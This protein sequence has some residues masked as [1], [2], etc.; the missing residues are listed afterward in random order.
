MTRGRESNTAYVAV[1]PPDVAHVGPRPGD[2][3]EASARS[4]LFGILQQVG[5]E[6]SAYEAITAEQDAWSSITQ[7]AAEYETIVATA[8]HDRPARPMGHGGACKRPVTCPGRGSHPL[9][10]FRSSS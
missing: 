1:D 4:I 7:L 10:Y 8:Q 2:D 6:L 3:A 5:A 9:G